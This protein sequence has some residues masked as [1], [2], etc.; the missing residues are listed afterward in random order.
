MQ[1]R[2]CGR[3]GLD[4][5]V[6]GFGAMRMHGD[7]VGPWAELVFQAAAAGFNYFET[8]NTYCSS[9]SEIKIGEGLRGVSRQDVLISTKCSCPKYPTADAARRTI[10]ES[11]RRLQVDYLDFYQLWGLEWRQFNEIAS[12]P[13]GTLAGVRKAVDEGLIRHVGLTSHDTPEN[14]ISLLQTGEFESITLQYNLL[15][16]RNE[17]AIDEARRLGIGVIVMGPLHGGILG[18]DS[19][20]IRG[21]MG[22]ASVRSAAEAAFRFVLNRPGVTCAISGMMNAQ[23]LAE[24]RRI[25]SDLR[26][27]SPAEQA[28]VDESLGRFEAASEALCTGCRYCMPCPEAVGISEIFRLANASRIYGLSEGSRRDYALFDVDWPYNA[29]KDASHCTECGACLPKCPQKINIPEQLAKAH[30]L[31]AG[32]DAKPGS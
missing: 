20:V 18:Y 5:T 26:P 22:A 25:A 13:G 17:P 10:E 31:L 30:E 15:D 12:T 23:E 21:L 6:I 24:N 11:L 32:P 8:S 28:A 4:L 16:R 7:D 29:F 19:E 9:T 2:P 14:M 3:T 1:K 27:L